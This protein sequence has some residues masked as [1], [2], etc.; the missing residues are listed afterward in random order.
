MRSFWFLSREYVYSMALAEVK[1]QA[2][3][4]LPPKATLNSPT[5]STW[6]K[7]PCVVPKVVVD[8]QSGCGRSGKAV[9]RLRYGRGK[10]NRLELA[11]SLLQ[12]L[13][14]GRGLAVRGTAC[15]RSAHGR[16]IR[17]GD[18]KSGLGR[19]H[20]T[21]GNPCRDCIG[22]GHECA[23]AIGHAAGPAIPGIRGGSMVAYAEFSRR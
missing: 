19:K 4:E 21:C 14:H 12:E 8:F 18:R 1:F 6:I 16:S 17:A 22:C 13:D 11:R 9:R 10:A 15:C 23:K 2:K 20:E 5:A 7:W 3:C